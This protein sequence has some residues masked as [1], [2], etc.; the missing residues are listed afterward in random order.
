VSEKQIKELEDRNSLA[1][2]WL[3][4]SPFTAMGP[5]SM[6]GQGTKVLQVTIA[7]P[8]KKLEGYTYGHLY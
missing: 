3:G 7:W 4:L 2:P 1:A 8:K 5:G 6:P